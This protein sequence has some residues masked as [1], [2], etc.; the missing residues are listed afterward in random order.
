MPA[1]VEPFWSLAPTRDKVM[2][3]ANASCKSTTIRMSFWAPAI[4]NEANKRP[5]GLGPSFKI[6]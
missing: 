1:I 3:S 5:N 2:P 4:G 6:V